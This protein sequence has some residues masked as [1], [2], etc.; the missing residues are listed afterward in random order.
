MLTGSVV[1]RS[2]LRFSSPDGSCMTGSIEGLVVSPESSSCSMWGE[3]L[4]KLIARK[5]AQRR[6]NREAVAVLSRPPDAP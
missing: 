4:A 1:G 5:R 3:A 2:L 6:W